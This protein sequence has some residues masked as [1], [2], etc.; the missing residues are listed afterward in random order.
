MLSPFRMVCRDFI[1]PEFCKPCLFLSSF[2]FAKIIVPY[3]G[4]SCPS[5][6]MVSNLL[7]RK[8]KPANTLRLRCSPAFL[9]Y[10]YGKGLAQLTMRSLNKQSNLLR[11]HG[12][13]LKRSSIVIPICRE[14]FQ[15][16]SADGSLI[17]L[18][19]LLILETLTPL[20]LANC[21]TVSPCSFR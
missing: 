10:C 6:W 5:C 21:A 16:R 17:P 19:I 18:S 8:I 15:T 3:R 12:I 7:S 20:L 2:Q 13:F 14:I 1:L 11:P 4:T 9:L